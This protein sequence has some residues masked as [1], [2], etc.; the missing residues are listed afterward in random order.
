LDITVQ[1]DFI[2]QLFNDSNL[3]KLVI[4]TRTEFSQLIEPIKVGIKHFH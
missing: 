1:H 4:G 3:L 2:I